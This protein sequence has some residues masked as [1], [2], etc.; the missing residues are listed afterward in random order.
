MDDA[1]RLAG[2]N[3]LSV[4]L[5]IPTASVPPWLYKMHPEVMGANDKGAFTYGGRKGFSID[6]P[7]MKVAAEKLITAMARHYGTN[8]QVIGWQ[9]SNEPGFPFENY[10]EHSLIAFRNWLK[11]HYGSIDKLNQS[12]NGVF[13]SNQ[14]N[15]WNEIHF[16]LNSA[17]GGWRSEARLDY[18]R[19]FS[20]SWLE[21]LRFEAS[22][23]NQH[24]SNQFRFINW[25]DTLWSVNVF[26]AGDLVKFTAWDNYSMMPGLSD[27]HDQFYA[28]LNHDLSRCSQ[29]SGQFLVSE[30]LAQAPANADLKGVRLQTYI[31][32]AHGSSGTLFYEW[33]SPLGGNEEGYPSVLALDG[34]FGPEAPVYR[35]MNEEFSRVAPM[36]K[37]AKTESDLAMIF[38]YDNEWNQGFWEGGTFRARKQYDGNFKR[39]YAG[40][41]SLHRN[42]DVLPPGSP[43]DRYR[44]IV[45]PGLQ[46]VSDEL[47]ASLINYVQRGGILVLN[48]KA[49]TLRMDGRLRPLPAPG[50]F[51]ESSGMQVTRYSS[52]RGVTNDYAVTLGKERDAYKVENLME[53]IHPQGAEVLGEFSGHGMERKPAVTINRHGKGYLVYIGAE[54]EDQRFYDALFTLLGKRF[55]IAPILNAPNEVEVVSR[56]VAETEYLFLLN[57]SGKERSVLL[58]QE[59]LQSGK[60]LLGQRKSEAILLPPYDVAILEKRNQPAALHSGENKK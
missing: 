21:W 18:R 1:I 48:A 37:N 11:N 47:A 13:W 36:L 4:V 15:D 3:G 2:Q 27:Y 10:D 12:W 8:P 9:F 17:E 58:P 5:G 46:M 16:P 6:S 25:P 55:Q 28:G 52:M 26:Q 43:L 42:I 19:Y 31:D 32:L 45:S 35:Q 41:K 54:I 39:Y 23:L 53:E 38:S 29:A 50:V 22:S 49:G 56:H 59:I 20:D 7:S 40:M 33:R 34:S 51:G 60:I 57:L 44:M 14:Y 30:Q 24:T